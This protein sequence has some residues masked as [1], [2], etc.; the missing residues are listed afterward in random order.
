MMTQNLELVPIERVLR[1][2]GKA[3]LLVEVCDV[4]LVPEDD[5]REKKMTDVQE[6]FDVLL[7][8]LV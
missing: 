6:K 8:K 2:S 5:L 3:E 1:V 4:D 7:C